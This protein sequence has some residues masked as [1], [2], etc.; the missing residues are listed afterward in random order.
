MNRFLCIALAAA[1]AATMCSCGKA[2][3]SQAEQPTSSASSVSSSW[4]LPSGRTEYPSVSSARE[5][6]Y[7]DSNTVDVDLTALSSTMVYAEVYNMLVNPDEYIGKTIKMAGAF[8]IYQ[9][10]TDGVLVEDPVAYACIIEDA[11]ACCTEG[12]EFVLADAR[13]Y[14][15]DYPPLGTQI[16]VTGEWQPYEDNGETWYHLVGATIV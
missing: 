5:N 4:S 15:D 7:A 10:V 8:E 14:P 13:T 3:T 2:S 1:L 9:L 16:T 11:T 6:A 12:I